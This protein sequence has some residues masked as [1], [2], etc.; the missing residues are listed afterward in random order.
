MIPWGKME[1]N[2]MLKSKSNEDRL[3]RV[4]ET[5]TNKERQK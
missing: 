2:K 1:I 4:S 5:M 3:K